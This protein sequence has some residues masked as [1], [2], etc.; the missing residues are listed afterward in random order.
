MARHNGIDV[1]TKAKLWVEDDGFIVPPER[2]ANTPRIG[3]DYAEPK[4]RNAQWRFVL[5]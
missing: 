5:Q 3:I 4:H 2:I 1:T